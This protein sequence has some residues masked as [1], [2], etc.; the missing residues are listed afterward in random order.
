MIA[1][2]IWFIVIL[3]VIVISHEFGH[4]MIARVHGIRVK[5]FDVGMGPTLAS[6]TKGETKF[7]L[8]LLPLGGACI[9]DGEDVLPGDDQEEGDKA[10]EL[11]EHSFRKAKVWHRIATVFAGP[12]FNFILAMLFAMIIVSNVGTDLPVVQG[13]TEGRAAEEAGL[14]EGDVILSINNERIHVWRDITLISYLNAGEGLKID[15]QRGSEKLSTTLY[16]TYS[17]EEGRY[18]IG[19]EGGTAYKECKGLELFKYSWYE[20][21]F[22]FRNTFKS[23]KQLVLGRLSRDDVSG[24]VGI[25]QVVGE[26]YDAAKEYGVK[27]VVLTMMN[28]AMLLSVNLGVINLLPLPA[29]DGGRLIFL[30]IEVVRG[31]PVPAEKEGIV[32]LIGIILFFILT[33]FVL[34]NDISRFFR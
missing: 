7:A 12:F 23:L 25:A 24:P 26:S 30:F 6:F 29:L 11:D 10:P 13:I 15:Y 31:K 21:L 14:L 32:H 33:I 9:F 20:L 1:T 3:S 4:F 18:Y 8:K 5:E 16:P 34:F 27:S 28:I 22:N 17:E 19:I 2:F